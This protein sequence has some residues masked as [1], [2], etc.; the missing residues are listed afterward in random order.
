MSTTLLATALALPDQ[1][2]TQ[3][4]IRGY[5]GAW[6]AHDPDKA[7]KADAILRNAEVRRRHTVRPA[8]WYLAHTSVTERSEVFREEMVR[9]TE[10][11]AR[12]ALE[13]SGVRAEE[14][15]LIVST[16]CTGIMIPPV[17]S[18]LMN[19]LPFRSTTRR[20]PLT[21]LGCVAGATAISHADQYLRAN[22]AS[23]ALIICGELAS[24]TAQNG[25]FSLTNIV[26]AAI[27]GDGAAA[28]VL[29]GA[30]HPRANGKEASDKGGLADSA[31]HR[32]PR[33][34]ASRGVQFPGTLDLMGFHN[35]DGGLKIF[36]SPRV[37]RVIRDELPRYLLPFLDEQGLALRDLRHFLLHP[38]GRKVL[39]GLE[40]E[41]GLTREQ[42]RISWEVLREFG[43]LS[44]ATVMFLLNQ[45]A[46]ECRPEPGDKGLLMAVGPGFACEMVLLQW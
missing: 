16:S 33:I 39:E 41:L 3:D 27:F 36:L 26:A 22:P 31:A 11:A 1:S 10:S 34:L 12:Q 7:A 46:R 6:L 38:G 21:E 24:L 44:S 15:G 32:H 9:L 25:D 29:A 4:E 13:L 18:H 20:M 43:N 5:L 17:E 8:E 28:A 14:I 40:R 37:P 35:T 42:T 30:E 23:A 45:F 19:R 2:Y